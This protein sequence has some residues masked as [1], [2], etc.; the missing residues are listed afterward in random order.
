MKV[1]MYGG[2]MQYL[3]QRHVVAKEGI[4][5]V[6]IIHPPLPLVVMDRIDEPD[7][8]PI[9]P[10]IQT[11]DP[12]SGKYFAA[13][14]R[15]KAIKPVKETGHAVQQTRKTGGGALGQASPQ[16]YHRS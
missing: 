11:A 14:P 4:P 16:A 2:I 3:L 10:V 15:P 5:A 13:H 9:H 12:F 1:E 6:G 7:Q 8:D